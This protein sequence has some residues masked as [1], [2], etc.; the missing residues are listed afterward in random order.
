VERRQQL[1]IAL[2]EAITEGPV[3]Q[4]AVRDDTKI[5]DMLRCELR[6][7]SRY[8]L[9]RVNSVE[10]GVATIA[11]THVHEGLRNG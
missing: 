3:R 8:F 11:I 6:G 9:A 10:L 1:G 2:Y 5:G 7:S 4:I